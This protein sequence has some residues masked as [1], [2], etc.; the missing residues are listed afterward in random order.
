VYWRILFLTLSGAVAISFF[1]A[2]AFIIEALSVVT[3]LQNPQPPTEITIEHLVGVLMNFQTALIVATFIL[4]PWLCVLL[5]SVASH[6][7]NQPHHLRWFLITSLVTFV[8][9]GLWTQWFFFTPTLLT[10]ARIPI[11]PFPRDPIQFPPTIT[12]LWG[13][14]ISTVILT[15][16]V[17]LVSVAL[18]YRWLVYQ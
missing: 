14:G 9:A 3:V 5:I 1:V 4:G 12:V 15:V 6:P 13:I 2:F 7:T 17:S 16:F 10:L 11:P 8:V 18:W